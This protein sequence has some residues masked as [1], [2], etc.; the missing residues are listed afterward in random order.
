MVTVWFLIA[1]IMYLALIGVFAFRDT[2]G[3]ARRAWRSPRTGAAEPSATP[4]SVPPPADTFAGLR[5][6]TA[7][8]RAGDDAAKQEAQ[9]VARLLDGDLDAERYRREMSELAA[10]DAKRHPLVF[11]PGVS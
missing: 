3:T 4:P 9:L 10:A 11:P 5:A 8:D 6:R 2:G 7:A 1:F